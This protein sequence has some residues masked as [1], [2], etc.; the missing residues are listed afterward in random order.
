MQKWSRS[1]FDRPLVLGVIFDQEE[2]VGGGFQ[3]ALNAC[4][5]AK[6]IPASLASTVFYSTSDKIRRRFHELGIEVKI[7]KLSLLERSIQKLREFIL[8]SSRP[9][10]YTLTGKVA[11]AERQFLRDKIDLIYFT[12]P[13]HYSKH[14]ESLNYIMTVWDLGHL[15]E[16]E[17]PEVSKFGQF[18]SRDCF[19]KTILP[20]A[21]AVIAESEA[22]KDLLLRSYNLS[23]ERVHVISLQPSQLLRNFSKSVH[24][25]L[26]QRSKRENGDPYIFYP[27]QFWPHKNH[28][29]ILRALS[30]L[31]E[32]YSV[33][34]NAI[35]CGTD[36]G[37][38]NYI[39]SCIGKY[40][41]AEHVLILDFVPYEKLME[42]YNDAL[43]LVMPTYLG[44]T[45]IPPLEAFYLGVPVLYSQTRHFE[46]QVNGAAMMINLRDPE[47]LAH[48]LIKLIK[49]PGFRDHLVQAGR[50]ESVKNDSEDRVGVLSQIILEF[51]DRRYTWE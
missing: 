49:D 30:I 23:P 19:Y 47:S 22:G 28:Q 3:Q 12:S 14:L 31:K 48:S 51:R 26:H 43:A 27:A 29:Y 44:P 10:L 15:M 24:T 42:L 32:D 20:Q 40:N 39:R 1:R 33:K 9:N 45:N 18:L 13:S 8:R 35:F 4:T 5:V 37:N 11:P 17:F 50:A 41:L 6:N 7:L 25:S 34:I 46:K 21:V 2:L 38:K 16:P 36:M